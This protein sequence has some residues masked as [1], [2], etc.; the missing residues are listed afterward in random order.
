[1]RHPAMR[2]STSLVAGETRLQGLSIPSCIHGCR[3]YLNRLLRI[4]WLKPRECAQFT[5]VIKVIP[6]TNRRME[7]ASN[8]LFICCCFPVLSA[9]FRALLCAR[10]PSLPGL[11]FSS[12]PWLWNAPGTGCAAVN[13]ARILPASAAFGA[14]LCRSVDPGHD[15]VGWPQR[16]RN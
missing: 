5:C 10:N 7:S 16:F 15:A 8:P 12:H 3:L 1:M 11:W 4:R 13:Q 9:G 6:A 2:A 14:S